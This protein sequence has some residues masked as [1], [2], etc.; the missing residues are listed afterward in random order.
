MEQ[1]TPLSAGAPEVDKAAAW[2]IFMGKFFQDVICITSY[3]MF[4]LKFPRDL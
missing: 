3:L 1:I 2:N 4:N